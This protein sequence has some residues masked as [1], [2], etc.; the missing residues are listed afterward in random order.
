MFETMV[1]ISSTAKTFEQSEID[2]ILKSSVKNNLASGITGVLIYGDGGFIQVLEGKGHALDS[3]Y[4][5]ILC[6]PRH[7][8]IMVLYREKVSQ[9]SFP[10]WGMACHK[11]VASNS[12]AD[13]IKLSSSNISKL[14]ITEARAEVAQLLKS[15]LKINFPHLAA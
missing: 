15:F 7:S 8:G 3:T 12:N 9:R 5:R 14:G 2:V 13:L 6:D 10:D 11:L 1:Y 4:K